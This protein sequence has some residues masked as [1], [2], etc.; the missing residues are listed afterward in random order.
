[1]R[2]T[3]TLIA[4]LLLCSVLRVGAQQVVID[5]SQIAASA[6]NAAEQVDYMLDQLGE[7]AEVGN[8][9]QTMRE[10][11]DNVFGEDGIG[12]KTLSILNDLGTL[13]RLTK[14]FN[15]T[16]K[17]TEEYARM[18][19]E[20]KQYRLSDANTMLMYLNEMKAQATMAIDVA[21][22]IINT[23]GLSKKE[24]KDE[25]EKIIQ[26][27]EDRLKK[28]EKMIAIEQETTM[29]AEGLGRLMEFVD[30]NMSTQDYV[31]SR[32]AY[33]NIRDAGKGSMNVLSIVIALLG[34]LS[35]VYGMV[36]FVRGGLAGDANVDNIFLRVAV[37]TAAGLIMITLI[38]TASGLNL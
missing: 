19:E 34:I 31:E 29:M 21:K 3:V 32:K 18:M 26:D 30:K 13:D 14:A 20:M 24:K 7:L 22:K 38:S 8:K 27:M 25:V 36:I 17:R 28:T 6:T 37:G 23:L 2:R 33:G 1:M 12:G 15:S 16:M 11:I 4:A 35:A 9:L 10:H 5:P